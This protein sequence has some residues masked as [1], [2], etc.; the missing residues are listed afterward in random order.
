MVAALSS[1]D[2]FC[3]KSNHEQ[4]LVARGGKKDDKQQF[5]LIWNIGR[6]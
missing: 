1:K 3:M 4:K 2:E 6:F 5:N